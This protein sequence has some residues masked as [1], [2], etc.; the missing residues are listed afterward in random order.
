MPFFDSNDWSDPNTMAAMSALANAAGAFGQAAMPSDRPVPMGAAFGAA[1]QAA[2]SGMMA[3]A[4]NA[5]AFRM[6]N[7]EVAGK[8][9][10]NDNSLLVENMLRRALGKP[11]LTQAD[12]QGHT[13]GMS[14]RSPIFGLHSA[15]PTSASAAGATTTP[16]E[17]SPQ[18]NYV[19]VPGGPPTYTPPGQPGDQSSDAGTTLGNN[20]MMKMLGFA[21]TDYAKAKQYADMLPAGPQ[22]IEAERAAAKAAGIG[23]TG[24]VR[25]GGVQTIW[26]PEKRNPDGTVGGYDVAFKNPALPE[27]YTLNDAGEAVPVPKGPEAV[28]DIAD[29]KAGAAAAYKPLNTYDAAG[30]E[31]IMPATA[32]KNGAP[33]A[34]PPPAFAQRVSQIESGANPAP[35]PNGSSTAAGTD[36][37]LNGTW[38]DQAKK[39]LPPQITQGKSDQQILALRSNP[40]VSA[41]LTNRY[42]NEN[43]QALQ[44]GGV[45]NVGAPELYLAHHFGAAG[46]QAILKAPVNTPLSQIL[47]PNVLKA[48]PDLQGAT[49]G[50][51]YA[52]SRAQMH[53]VGTPTP[54]AQVAPGA[55]NTPVQNSASGIPTK[56]D[57]FIGKL[58]PTYQPP[59]RPAVLMGEPG[60]GTEEIQKVDADR[61]EQYSKEAAGGQKVYTNLQQLYQIMGRGLSTGN[62]TGAATHLTN[63]AR[64]LGMDSLIP[65]NFD[66]NDSGA[67]NKLATDLVF[68]QL[69]QIGG[70]PMVSEIEGLKQ[71]NP[72]TSL[73]P[74]ANSEILNNI[75]A[76]QRWRD[77]RADLGRQYMSRFGSLGDFDAR[78]NEQYPEVDTFNKITNTAAKAGW[79]LPGDA[80]TPSGRNTGQLPSTAASLLK[81]NVH[82]TFKNGQVWTIENGQPLRIK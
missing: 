35:A 67:F 26:N 61:L 71:A 82:T 11:E 62:M 31:T 20:L 29:R 69:K 25:S 72:N 6:G 2:N 21:P 7:Q 42:A 80:S 4:H 23:V 5:Q 19:G 63:Y 75:L 81:P 79:K 56:L 18:G 66:P 24:D 53:G 1:A 47:P 41:F 65:K 50:D 57:D 16:S 15:P 8:V 17:Q 68:A 64:Q 38:L 32:L 13:D 78:F 12:L 60:K 10:S 3:G 45:K 34:S 49:V 28:S 76:D 37:F 74:A 73:T 46:A 55:P 9:I 30:N 14:A 58:G 33:A 51:V 22:K 27:G 59:G 40:E 44:A 52:H 36:Q 54:A 77:A 70:R 43:S 48:N 39:N